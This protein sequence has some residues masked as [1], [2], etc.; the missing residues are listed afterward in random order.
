MNVTLWLLQTVKHQPQFQVQHCVRDCEWMFNMWGSALSCCRSVCFNEMWL[1][2]FFLG[3][4]HTSAFIHTRSSHKGQTGWLHQTE[5]FNGP[6][7]VFVCLCVLFLPFLLSCVVRLNLIFSGLL[8][9]FPRLNSFNS[10]CVFGFV[11]CVCDCVCV[12]FDLSY[13]YK[14]S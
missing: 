2:A 7:D 14:R 5:E 12:V 6:S 10:Q 8:N 3:Y 11:V 9:S 1:Q 13:S 4:M